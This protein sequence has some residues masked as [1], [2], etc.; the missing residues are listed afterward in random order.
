MEEALTALLLGDPDVAAL[1]VRRVNWN[2]MPR[3]TGGYPRIILQT[4]SAPDGYVMGGRSGLSQWEVQLDVWGRSKTETTITA[5]ACRDLLSGYRGTVG[6]VSFRGIF[7]NR[8][9]DDAGE[10]SGVEHQLHRAR[11]DLN[12]N[13]KHTE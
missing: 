1:V 6:G 10:T 11:I 4:V 9:S 8:A 2:V 13:W 7:I 5:R 3:D 12:I